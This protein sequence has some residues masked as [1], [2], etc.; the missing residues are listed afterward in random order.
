MHRPALNEARERIEAGVSGGIVVARIDR[1]GRTVAR[2]LDAIE[3]IDQAEGVIITAEGDFDT[4][5]PTGE[6]VLNLMLSLAQFEL[7]RIRDNWQS[8]KSRAVSR[9][10]HIAAR[11]P[12]G[13]RKN[14]GG[15]LEGSP[16]SGSTS[17]QNE[18]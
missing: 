3:E 17:R 9:G 2:A 7:R 15:R 11:I 1:F 16:L 12:P 13:Y 6:L 18:T 8:A 10:V 14:G 5:T 4:S